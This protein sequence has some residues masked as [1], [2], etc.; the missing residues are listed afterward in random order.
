MH[1]LS[2]SEVRHTFGCKKSHP[3]CQPQSV[4]FIICYKNFT[5]CQF[6]WMAI[7]LVEST[8]FNWYLRAHLTH[9]LK[10]IC[11]NLQNI[12]HLWKIL[13]TCSW[14]KYRTLNQ[15]CCKLWPAFGCCTLQTLV[16]I[17]FF[18]TKKLKKGKK[19]WNWHKFHQKNL[20]F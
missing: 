7:E 16:E 12:L 1:V 19:H 13:Q 11:A 17:C 15:K 9:F 8:Y 20:F 5:F 18:H 10:L 3:P 4:E 6:L 2:F 14:R